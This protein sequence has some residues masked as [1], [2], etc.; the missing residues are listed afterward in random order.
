MAGIGSGTG[1]NRVID[2][3]NRIDFMYRLYNFPLS[4]NCYKVR[5]LLTQLGIPF[6]LVNTDVLQQQTKLPD[7]LQKN[8]NGKV[9]VLELSPDVFLSESGAILLYL[10][11]G[12]DFLPN[13][14]YLKAQVH[15]WMFFG[16]FSLDPNLARPRF[17]ISVAKQPEKV[18][19]LFESWYALGNAALAVMEQHLSQQ[20]FFVDN[21]YTIADMALY[22]YTH[23]A[24][25]GNYDLAIY[26]NI[27]QWC[28]RIAA[29]PHHVTVT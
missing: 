16:Q 23:M 18:Q 1:N 24:H 4:G 13:D 6:E 21:R 2:S 27:Q 19:H 15:Q 17:F 20:E 10:A 12:T 28:D 25:Q 14:R 3:V 26:P 11:E 7:F 29:Q 9:P 8:P 5:L 22:A